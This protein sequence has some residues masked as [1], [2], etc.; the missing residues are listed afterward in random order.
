VTR[1]IQKCNGQK[2]FKNLT[3]K[4]ISNFKNRLFSKV[5]VTDFF[6]KNLSLKI[7]IINPSMHPRKPIIIQSKEMQCLQ[8]ENVQNERIGENNFLFVAIHYF[9]A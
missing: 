6:I 1:K 9:I 2:I 8:K 3:A 5:F 7:Q 4:I